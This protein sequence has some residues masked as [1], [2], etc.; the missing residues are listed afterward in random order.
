MQVQVV[1]LAVEVGIA[2]LVAVG[3][4][5]VGIVVV[6][7]GTAVAAVGKQGQLAVGTAAVQVFWEA[8]DVW[9]RHWGYRQ[10]SC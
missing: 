4:V 7:V 1:P 8:E 10:K 5:E 2:V 3:T 6:A 9:G